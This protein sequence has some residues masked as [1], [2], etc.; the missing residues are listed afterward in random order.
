[1]KTRF[2]GFCVL[3]VVLLATTLA[4]AADTSTGPLSGPFGRLAIVGISGKYAVYMNGRGPAFY[5]GTVREVDSRK[6]ILA[7]GLQHVIL[8]DPKTDAEVYSGYVMVKA[9]KKAIL[10]VDLSDTGYVDWPEGAQIQS[11]PRYSSSGS[12][13]T[14]AAVAP[15]SAKFAIAGGNTI[16][17]GQPAKLVWVTD[18][19]RTLL[20]VDNVALA[21]GPFPS[22]GELVVDP[23]EDTT[24]L[25]ESFGPGGVYT[26]TQTVHINKDVD[27]SLTP[28]PEVVRY[29]RVGNNVVEPGDIVL[30]WT[31]SN[32]TNVTIDGM[33]VQGTAGAQKVKFTPSLNGYGPV[34]E[35]RTYTMTATN[36]CGSTVTRTASVKVDGSIDPEIVAEAAPEPL[37]P[38]LPTTA[39]PL[40]LIG[41]LGLGSLASGLVLRGMRKK[42]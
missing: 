9:N 7:P 25:L 8:V 38:K 4:L 12:G 24:Y 32:A 27:A 17:C 1:M 37:P 26:T 22:S 33:P 18:G 14:L 3:V 6:L 11:L 28:A 29:H 35:T 16:D 19:G 39:S 40:P 23:K 20:K 2:L 34:A 30:N 15:V 31:A 41:L 36:P 21:G 42:R 5:V 13:T 10:H